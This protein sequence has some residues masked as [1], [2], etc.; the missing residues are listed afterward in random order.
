MQKLM[1]RQDPEWEALY[2]A[3][4]DDQRD[5]DEC[6]AWL[7]LGL[8]REGSLAHETNAHM[9]WVEIEV[10]APE[11]KQ[12]IGTRMLAKAAELAQD[13]NRTLLIGGSDED[14]GKA[15]IDAIGAKVAQRWRES[16][17]YLEKVDWEM[18]EE[19]V[20]DGE[21]RSP[22]TS[23][24]FFTN[25]P[26]D[27]ILEEYCGLL[28]DVSNQEPRGDLDLGDE[29][30]TPAIL[31]ER[32]G[33]FVGAGGTILRAVTQ[34]REGDL[35]GL[36]TMGYL[37]DE[38]SHI[39]QWMTGVKDVYRGRGLGKWLKAAMLLKVREEYPEVKVVRT[40]NATSNEAMLSINVRLGFKPYREG[41]EAQIPLK[42]V[43]A[44]LSA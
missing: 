14:D 41:V 20:T 28:Q 12:G 16:R 15:F 2:F 42:A 29:F 35:S 26:D 32:V 8:A 6:L 27:S 18:M 39:H 38:E 31:R 23:L 17:L 43:Q 44:Y 13:R 24:Q 33:T 5:P 1:K 30:L 7:E 11:R 36:T 3:T 21:K 19:W 37:P 25:Y 4:L 40:G 10:L 34:E 22:E 9:V